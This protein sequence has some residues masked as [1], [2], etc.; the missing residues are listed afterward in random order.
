[1]RRS[2]DLTGSLF[3]LLVSILLIITTPSVSTAADKAEI[4]DLR[5]WSSAGQTRVVIYLS[6][7]VEYTKNR[8]ADPDRLYFDLRKSR[9]VREVQSRLSVGDGILKSVRAAQF[10]EDTV[11]VVLDLETIEDYNVFFF[12]EP[13]RMVIDI[14]AKRPERL[15]TKRIIVLDPGH[16]GHDPGAVGAKGLMEKDVVLDIAMKARKLLSEDPSIDVHL[17]R[18]TDVFISLEDRTGFARKKDA[19]LFVSVH[20]NASPNRSARGIETYLLNWTNEEEAIRVAARENYISV[21]RMKERLAQY[22]KDD[23]VGIMLSD[24]NRQWNREESLKLANHVQRSLV[25]DVGRSFIDPY[26][27]GVKGALFYVLVGATMPSILAEVSFVSNPL[28][29]KLLGKEEYR[30][31]IAQSIATGIKT[32]LSSASPVQKVAGLKNGPAPATTK[33]KTAKTKTYLAKR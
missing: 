3:L 26:D 30:M 21:K 12:E 27:L 31:T 9:I 19:D 23:Y 11:R 13:T 15:V 28:E 22:R 5:Y 2:L 6:H 20:A 8:L 7:P 17:T 10:N 25:A 32:Y 33:K 29:E 18:E 1:M 24:L 4:K 14:N 16:G